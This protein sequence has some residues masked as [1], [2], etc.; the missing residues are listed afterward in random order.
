LGDAITLGSSFIGLADHATLPR[1]FGLVSMGVWPHDIAAIDIDWVASY[2]GAP[3]YVA[4]D[5]FRI[6]LL[7]LVITAGVPPIQDGAGVRHRTTV[8]EIA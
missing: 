1:D 5:E 6:I 7:K 4:P 8:A 2:P 3:G